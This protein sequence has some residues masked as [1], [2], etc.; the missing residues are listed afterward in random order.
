MGGSA[1]QPHSAAYI[2]DVGRAA[3]IQGT[4][5]EALGKVWLSPH[6]PAQTQRAMIETASRI[7]GTRPK[8]R[9]I[10]PLMMHLA[11]LFMP[12]TRES[13]EMMYE[14]TEPFIVDSAKIQNAF[15]LESTPLEDGIGKTVEWYQEDTKG[16]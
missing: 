5:E 4:R 11:G 9:E 7:A 6:A 12:E 3:S 2:E 8:V 13:V 1:D 10:S 16:N 14:F 15:G